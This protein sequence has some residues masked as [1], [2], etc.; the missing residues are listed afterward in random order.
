MAAGIPTNLTEL[1]QFRQL[2]QEQCNAAVTAMETAYI[3]QRPISTLSY[4]ETQ[5]AT[6]V[7]RSLPTPPPGPIPFATL[8]SRRPTDEEV[9]E[10]V[11]PE[12]AP[13]SEWQAVAVL[14]TLYRNCREN[15]LP[16]PD[17][18]FSP[19]E[20]YG[21]LENHF[22]RAM[23]PYSEFP[24]HCITREDQLQRLQDVAHQQD[25]LQATAFANAQALIARAPA[26][27][28]VHGV[29]RGENPAGLGT[30]ADL[31]LSA[32]NLGVVPRFIKPFFG[33]QSLN[34][35]NNQLT[36]VPYLA[37]LEQLTTLSL[38]DN[39]LTRVPRAGLLPESLVNMHLDNN[40]IV[41]FEPITRPNL[42]AITVTG[43]PLLVHPSLDAVPF[44]QASLVHLP[45][46]IAHFRAQ[47]EQLPA[48]SYPGTLYSH[49]LSNPLSSLGEAVPAAT[50]ALFDQ[51]PASA[52]GAIYGQI[53]AL[54]GSP[55]GDPQFG[56]NHVFDNG[57]L[58]MAAVHNAILALA[59]TRLAHLST[60][61]FTNTALKKL[62]SVSLE[63]LPAEIQGQ[64]YGRIWQE[65][66]SPM[67]DMQYGKNHA[68]DDLVRFQAIFNEFVPED[69]TEPA[70]LA[71]RALINNFA[72]SSTKQN[73][74]LLVAAVNATY[75]P[76]V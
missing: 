11:V 39:H 14:Q 5:I 56:A 54:S 48:G 34:L 28:V 29:L 17:L 36:W 75:S 6:R 10:Q 46:T 12:P 31:D 18:T 25:D 16:D 57:Q 71:I 20:F 33:L 61:E 8:L 76:A 60:P 72:G 43:N 7:L 59:D 51:L 47:S 13:L 40:Q 2:A 66:R 1:N 67:G 58:F 4:E 63:Q 69:T 55:G 41:M 68:L 26:Q 70:G 3:S 74:P 21:R 50:Q 32:L 27:E 52:K 45:Q 49:L 44:N 64:I 9:A 24:S 19:T 22:D 35:D 30:V 37:G 53:W 42:T 23:L 15:F 73:M 62:V 38:R 65:D